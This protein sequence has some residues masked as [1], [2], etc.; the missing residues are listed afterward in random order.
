MADPLS[1]YSRLDGLINGSSMSRN[2]VDI[3][4]KS[5]YHFLRPYLAAPYAAA[6]CSYSCR[7][8][9]WII[10]YRPCPRTNEQYTDK[11]DAFA[12]TI[13]RGS[14][15]A[16]ARVGVWRLHSV[17][18]GSFNVWWSERRTRRQRI[19][20]SIHW[21]VWGADPTPRASPLSGD[22]KIEILSHPYAQIKKFSDISVPPVTAVV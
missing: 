14:Y 2:F 22:V 3:V 4:Q 21:R 10:K 12:Q 7:K 8:R 19:S 11:C 5:S 6:T 1:A 20:L 16:A 13:R 18:K 9:W 15:C 17:S